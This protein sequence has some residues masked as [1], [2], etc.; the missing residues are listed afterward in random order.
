MTNNPIQTQK[1][2]LAQM[3]TISKK[4]LRLVGKTN[5]QYNLIKEGDR[6]LLGLS[7]GKDSILLATILAYMH[8]HAPLSL[9]IRRLLLIMA[10]VGSMSIF[11]SIVRIL[12]FPTSFTAPIFMRFWSKTSGRGQFIVAFA[13]V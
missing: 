13:L 4:I 6:I 12:A 9:I 8:K 10:G 1:K 7:G 3:P 2:N 5:A 11:S